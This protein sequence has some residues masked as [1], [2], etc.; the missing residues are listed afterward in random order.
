MQELSELLNNLHQL[1]VKRLWHQLTG[2][3]LQLVLR[4]ELQDGDK[5]WQLYTNV[6]ADFE[7]K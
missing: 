3:L 4:P 6:I 2:V 1:Y 5:L 7:L